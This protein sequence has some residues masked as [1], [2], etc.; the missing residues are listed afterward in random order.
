MHKVNRNVNKNKREG[1]GSTKSC[2][3]LVSLCFK[4]L[5]QLSS[6]VS[7]RVEKCTTVYDFTHVNIRSFYFYEVS[8]SNTL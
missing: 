8:D 2:N 1:Y 6:A 4:P 7:E 3:I 5:A